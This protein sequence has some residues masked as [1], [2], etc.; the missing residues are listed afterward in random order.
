MFPALATGAPVLADIYPPWAS[1]EGSWEVVWKCRAGGGIG[2]ALVKG[3]RLED[4]GKSIRQR[5]QNTGGAEDSC[6]WTRCRGG[7]GWGAQR[8]VGF[9]LVICVA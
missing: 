1:R 3:G 4:A 8:Y 5:E 2:D 6:L 7:L 9:C